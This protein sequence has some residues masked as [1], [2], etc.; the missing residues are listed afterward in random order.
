MTTLYFNCESGISGDMFTGAML[1]LTGEFDYL[2]NELNKLNLQNFKIKTQKVDKKGIEAIKFDVLSEP[3]KKHRHLKHINEIIENSGIT[4]VAKKLAKDIFLELGKAEAKAHETTIER[5]HFHEVGAIDSIIDIVSAA[6]LLDK[7][8]PENIYCGV[9]SVGHGKIEIEHGTVDLPAPAT[10]EILKNVPLEIKNI[11]KELTTPTGASIIKTVCNRFIDS[12]NFEPE[13]TGYGAGTRDLDTPNVLKVQLFETD[14][15]F[16]SKVLLETNIDDMNPEI[17]PYVIKKLI[18]SGAMEAYVQPCFMKKNRIG[19]ILNVLCDKELMEKLT[20]IIFRETSTLGI[21]VNRINK[22][23]LK[24]ETRQVETEFGTIGV[25]TS[26]LKGK[27][28]KAK[29]EYEE[30]KKI[31]EKEGIPLIDVYREINRHI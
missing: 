2:D 15:I 31:A 17:Y 23:E 3:E 12:I 18:K 16:S 21:R 1:D 29:P 4:D 10:R 30:C 9:I 5:V 20:E 13:K 6:I 24:R 26:L 14:M 8:K 22:V 11:P 19:T 27:P 28:V 7:L 25:K